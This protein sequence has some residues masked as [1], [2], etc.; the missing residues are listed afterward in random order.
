MRA[1]LSSHST[2][3]LGKSTWSI[4]QN[5]LRGVAFTAFVVS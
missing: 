1:Q 5:W 2:V 4:L 3:P